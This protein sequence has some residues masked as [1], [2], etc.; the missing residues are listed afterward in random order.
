MSKL[1]VT[2]TADNLILRIRGHAVILD[3]DLAALYGTTTKRLNEQ[4]KRNNER[5][6]DDFVFQLTEK[7]WR[8]L[9]SQ[10]ATSKKGHGGRRY[11]PHVF[12]EHGALMAANVVKSER[13][14][15]MSIAVVRAFAKLRRMALSVEGLA[16]KVDQLERKYDKQFRVVFDTI[17]Q[18]IMAPEEPSKKIAG[19]KND[20]N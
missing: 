14:I 2:P 13:A 1:P 6:P 16:R 11:M 7:E 20:Q 5:F 8:S 3:S 15:E 19:F 18:L 9:R 10:I 12:T 17:R 4:V